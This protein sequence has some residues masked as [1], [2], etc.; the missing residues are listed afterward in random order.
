[1]QAPAAR[2]ADAHLLLHA[3]V[4]LEL[5]LRQDAREVKARTEVRREDVDLE[6]E[7]AQSRLD[8]EMARRELA[9]ARALHVPHRFLRRERERRMAVALELLRELKRDAVH[10]PQHQHV[11]V[12]DGDVGLAAE[13]SDR[14]ALHDHYHALDVGRDA[15]GRLRPAR[16]GREGVQRRGRRDA[17]EISAELFRPSLNLQRSYGTT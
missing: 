8:A 15:L 5:E 16:V 9:V 17:A 12:L 1:M 11:E 10:A 7:R 2:L 6:P 13:R 14:D 4:G 3:L